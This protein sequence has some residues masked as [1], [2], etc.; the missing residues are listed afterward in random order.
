MFRLHRLFIAV[1]YREHAAQ[2]LVAELQREFAF[3]R[4]LTAQS[5][6]PGVRDGGLTQVQNLKAGQVLR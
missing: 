1:R 4:F 3:E 6:Q 2:N 5:H